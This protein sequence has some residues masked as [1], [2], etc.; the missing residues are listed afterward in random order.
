MAEKSLRQKWE[1]KI[2]KCIAGKKIIKAGYHLQG[3]YK[4][5]HLGTTYEC[6]D[7]QPYLYLD[8]E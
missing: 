2:N 5:T 3:H 7:N 6:I 1:D 8:L 4:F